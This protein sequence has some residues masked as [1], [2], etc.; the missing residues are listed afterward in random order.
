MQ[1]NLNCLDSKVTPQQNFILTAPYTATEVTNALFQLH[2]M[3]APGKD[4][5]SVAFF[6]N[7]WPIIKDDFIRDCLAFLN[8]GILD[9]ETNSTLITLIPKLKG[10]VKVTDYRPISLIG[11]KMKAISKAIVNRL[12]SFLD[13]VIS[14]EQCTF[15]KNRVITDNLIVSHELIH[16]IRNNNCQR[17]VYGSLKLDIAKAYDTPVTGCSCRYRG[18]Y[19]SVTGKANFS[20]AK[21]ARHSRD[22]LHRP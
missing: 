1:S 14:V 10:A 22:K 20:D 2:P 18:R 5:F 16:Y 19:R 21:L 17:R 8:D 6:H 15:V 4:G 13:D 11:V 9:S 3:K 12:Q 7:Y